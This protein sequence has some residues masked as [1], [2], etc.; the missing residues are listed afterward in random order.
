MTKRSLRSFL[1]QFTRLLSLLLDSVIN[2]IFIYFF[3]VIA[4]LSL[5]IWANWTYKQLTYLVIK[6]CTVEHNPI[7]PILIKMT[8][9]KISRRRTQEE[10]ELLIDLVKDD[11]TFLTWALTNA[12]TKSMVDNKW[13]DI[14]SAINSLAKRTPCSTAKIKKMV[15]CKKPGETWCCAI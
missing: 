8:S 2:F 10:V 9:K 13:R 12:K 6:E 5:I 7:L 1:L 11:Y 14:A 3:A 15:W 4:L